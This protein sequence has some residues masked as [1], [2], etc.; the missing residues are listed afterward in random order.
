MARV[1]EEVASFV[2]P[3]WRRWLS[4]ALKEAEMDPRELGLAFALKQRGNRDP[5][6]SYTKL[7]DDGWLKG[8][9]TVSADSA[10]AVGE[11]LSAR[12]LRWCSGP[13]ALYG[14]GHVEDLAL[15][16]AALSKEKGNGPGVGD[17]ATRVASLYAS[18]WALDFDS[19][20]L[21]AHAKRNGPSTSIDWI[22]QQALWAQKRLEPTNAEGVAELYATA[23]EKVQRAVR[24]PDRALEPAIAAGR[25]L[26][27]TG[28]EA[29][30]ALLQPWVFS[31]AAPAAQQHALLE[32]TSARDLA[33]LLQRAPWVPIG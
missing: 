1:R 31:I 32:S 6:G 21:R 17:G 29:F 2:R 20:A 26:G 5:G 9:K 19:A 33:Y 14:A 27:E 12:G 22:E 23:W 16:F 30:W 8:T 24:Q 25:A 11:I 15:F 18:L 13:A 28:F 7:I 3:R 10:F 4:A